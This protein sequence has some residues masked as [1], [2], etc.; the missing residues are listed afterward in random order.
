MNTPV[1]KRHVLHELPEDIVGV[2]DNFSGAVWGAGVMR[3]GGILFYWYCTNYDGE[4]ITLGEI[5]QNEVPE[6]VL[7]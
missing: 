3:H 6:K 2:S 1:K 4:P 5:L 7:Y